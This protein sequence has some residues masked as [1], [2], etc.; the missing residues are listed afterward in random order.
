MSTR[1]TLCTALLAALVLAACAS[2]PAPTAAQLTY[3]TQPEGAT[4]FEGSQSIGV[5]PVTRTYA[6]EGGAQTVRTPL[7]TAVWPSGAKESYYT[8]LPLGADRVATIERPA[9]A[10]GLQADLDNAKKLAQSRDQDARRGT[11]AALREQRRNSERCKAQ[12]AGG[13]RAVQDDCN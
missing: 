11:E 7:V 13:G 10:P 3:E 4:L 6:A 1:R 5:A 12:M 2:P 8:V 9:N